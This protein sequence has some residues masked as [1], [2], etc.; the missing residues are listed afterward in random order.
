VAGHEIRPARQ[1]EA[2]WI[3]FIRQFTPLSGASFGDRARQAPRP[4]SL[5][6]F[7]VTPSIMAGT[8]CHWSSH[9]SARQ[10]WAL[11]LLQF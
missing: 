7:D 11:F 1:D 8:M 5:Y 3:T 4:N 9:C 2:L 10:C 6:S